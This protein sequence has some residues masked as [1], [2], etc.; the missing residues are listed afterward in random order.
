M[1]AGP[2]TLLW[3]ASAPFRI[4]AADRDTFVLV[5]IAPSPALISCGQ[6]HRQPTA[7]RSRTRAASAAGTVGGSRI[8]ERR[9]RECPDSADLAAGAAPFQLSKV[10]IAKF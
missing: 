3:S 9:R 7:T 8:D 6:T 2:L 5:L 4:L 10:C 1:Q